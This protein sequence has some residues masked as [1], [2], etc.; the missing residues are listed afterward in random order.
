[1][2][3]KRLLAEGFHMKDAVKAVAGELGLPRGDVYRE[4]LK[5]KEDLDR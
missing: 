1:M 4:A 3:L 5:I 2:E